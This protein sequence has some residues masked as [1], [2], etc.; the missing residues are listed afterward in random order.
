M[1]DFRFYTDTYLGTRIPEK[2]F[3]E[4]MARA[5]DALAAFRRRYTVTGGQMEEN[6]AL[7]AMAEAIYGTSCRRG[8]VSAT[9]GSVSVRYADGEKQL[10]RELLESAR[11]YLGIYRGVS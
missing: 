2:Q 8:A 3:P 7:C 1:V 10:W 11:I 9:V 5:R 6:M 4:S